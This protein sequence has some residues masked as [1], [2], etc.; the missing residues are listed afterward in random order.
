MEKRIK[1]QNNNIFV[2][3]LISLFCM[4]IYDFFALKGQ[5]SQVALTLFKM[6]LV[7]FIL[8]GIINKK[9]LKEITYQTHLEDYFKK[10]K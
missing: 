4:Y 1:I 9:K 7:L 5:G 6:I 10:G 3:F 2:I 8:I